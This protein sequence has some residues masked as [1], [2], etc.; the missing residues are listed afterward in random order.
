MDAIFL[1]AG[2]IVC[3]V[4]GICVGALVLGLLVYLA[5]CAWVEA[6]NKWR[7]ICKAESL[8]Y[9]YRKNRNEYLKWKADGK[10]HD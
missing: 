10:E 7:S 3:V 5:G 9:E 1:T 4:G 6:S 8:I 2:K